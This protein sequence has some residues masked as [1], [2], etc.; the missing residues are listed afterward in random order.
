MQKGLKNW[1]V[2]FYKMFLTYN[3]FGRNF[4]TLKFSLLGKIQVQKCTCHTY[5]EPYILW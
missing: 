3:R 1:S 4:G 2:S 5:M